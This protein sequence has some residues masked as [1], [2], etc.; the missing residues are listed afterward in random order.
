MHLLVYVSLSFMLAATLKAE[1]LERI[2]L[3][4]CSHQ[5]KAMPIL[6]SVIADQ[7]DLRWNR[8]PLAKFPS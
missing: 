8:P 2:I 6:D 3:R 5:D 4:S 7:P 1:P